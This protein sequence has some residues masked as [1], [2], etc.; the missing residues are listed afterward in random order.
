LDGTPRDVFSQVEELQKLRL[1]V[2]AMTELGDIL[3]KEGLE[4]PRG[5]LT[6][7]EMVVALCP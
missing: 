5:V 4:I 3:A 2:P 6:V 1:D 7:E